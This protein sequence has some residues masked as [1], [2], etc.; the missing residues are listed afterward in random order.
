VAS[1]FDDI[2]TSNN[3]KIGIILDVSFINPPM[4]DEFSKC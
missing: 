3:I 4:S 2:L 1:L